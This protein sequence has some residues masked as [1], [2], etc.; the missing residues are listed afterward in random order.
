MALWKDP[1]KDI[2]PLMAAQS[3]ITRQIKAHFSLYELLELLNILIAF[4]KIVKR[5]IW[6]I[7]IFYRCAGIEL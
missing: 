2:V 1:E 3:S 5:L 7:N 6:H 4:S